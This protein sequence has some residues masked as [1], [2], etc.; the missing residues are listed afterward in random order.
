MVPWR[1]AYGALR[2]F[3]RRKGV[4]RTFFALAS[5]VAAF[6]WSALLFHLN[7]SG[8]SL[9]D[10]PYAPPL[11]L[12]LEATIP[13]YKRAEEST[14]LTLLEWYQVFSYQEY[15]DFIDDGRPSRFPYFS[16][17]GQSWGMYCEAYGRTEGAYPFNAGNH[18]MLSVIG[19]SFSLE[20]AAKGVYEH[21]IGWLTQFISH[22]TPEDRY[23]AATAQDYG[24]FIETE[25]WYAYP[26]GRK[27]VGVW[28]ENDFFGDDFVRK[29]ER[30][31]FLT[32]EYG[33]KA[34]YAFVIRGAT[35]TIFGPPP[36]EDY[37][38]VENVSA[39]QFS[40]EGVRKVRDLGNASYI[41]VL[42]HYQG[43]TDIVPVLARNGVRF[44]DIAGNDEIVLT[45]LAPEGWTYDLS[46][47]EG[48]YSQV[49]LTQPDLRRLVVRAPV[50]G[51]HAVLVDL[52]TRGVRVE[53]LFD[54]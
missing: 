13:G 1:K 27:A 20:Y 46:E 18:L 29:L 32:Y 49:V 22:T 33:F 9:K 25:P 41:I 31:V 51:L 5:L 10:P 42:P 4:R 53:H 37:L 23:A 21:T 3:V 39:D 24:R 35:Q 34:G 54:Y 36:S 6:E 30:K 26:F 11:V 52:E 48:L 8:P 40:I 28:K 16:A 15:G 38:W 43:F 17:I 44:V 45:V 2:R 19:V 14:Y 50:E 12:E 47:G 7:C